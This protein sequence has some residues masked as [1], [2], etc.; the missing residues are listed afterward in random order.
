MVALL[1]T[2]RA[3]GLAALGLLLVGPAAAGAQVSAAGP[4]ED[5]RAASAG[6]ARDGRAVDERDA[7]LDPVYDRDLILGDQAR[8]QFSLHRL[9]YA[10]M[11]ANDLKLQLSFKYRFLEQVPAFVSFTN[12]IVW[13]IYEPRDPTRDAMY[14]P[15]IFYRWR[16]AKPTPFF[17]DAGY[18][19]ASNGRGDEPEKRSLDRF[20]VRGLL[21]FELL[22]RPLLATPTGYLT[23]SES[24]HSP[25]IEDYL[26]Q[27]E[28]GLVW[29]DLFSPGEPGSDLD[30]LIDIVDPVSAEGS[31]TVGLQLRLEDYLW[32]PNLYVQYFSGYGDTLLEYNER[33]TELRFG[34]TFYY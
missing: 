5:V 16:L 34:M 25:D 23:A 27:W 15:E 1:R 7:Q 10:A 18:W 13:D 31:Y 21:D 22:G 4:P 11:G 9:N 32:S 2:L 6:F 14:N 20:F 33:K 17:F 24:V 30:L 8:E 28:L 3:Q 12:V 19:H 26:G 29:K